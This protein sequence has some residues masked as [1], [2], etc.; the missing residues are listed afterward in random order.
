[1]SN[2][3]EVRVS[4]Q[5]PE[6]LAIKAVAAALEPLDEEARGRVLEWAKDRFVEA[7]L[8]TIKGS[9]FEAMKAQLDCVREYANRIGVKETDLVHALAAQRTRAGLAPIE[10][11]TPETDLHPADPARA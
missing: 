4:D 2:R 10:D 7:P 9:T 8:R 1:M 6:M 5:D 11:G 3:R